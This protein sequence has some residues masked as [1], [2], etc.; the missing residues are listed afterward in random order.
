MKEVNG[1]I[2][3]EF[4]A[5]SGGEHCD[6]LLRLAGVINRHAAA[7]FS[8]SVPVEYLSGI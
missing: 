7:D 1:K 8:V 2:D 3:G 5:F 4:A 6:K